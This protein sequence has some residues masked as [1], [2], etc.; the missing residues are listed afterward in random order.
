M[1][2]AIYL[3]LSLL[4]IFSKGL[5]AQNLLPRQTIRGIII[6]EQSNQP[7]SGVTIRIETLDAQP[8]S[9][10]TATG[11]FSISEVPVGRH[12]LRISRVGYEE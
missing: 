3:S 4:L 12:R 9:I 8:S 7:L 11:A 2:K 10:S 5:F 6:D 1:K